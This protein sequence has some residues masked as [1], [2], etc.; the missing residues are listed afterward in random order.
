MPCLIKVEH[1]KRII[2]KIGIHYG[3]KG[4]PDFIIS[5]Y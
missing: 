4:K 5:A 1:S 3:I 2:E